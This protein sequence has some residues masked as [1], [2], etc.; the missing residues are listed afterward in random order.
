MSDDVIGDEEQHA[1]FDV[2]PDWKE[3]LWKGMPDYS[4]ENLQ[5]D[6]TL[7]VHFRDLKDREDFARLI[8]QKLHSKTKFIWHPKAEIGTAADKVFRGEKVIPRYPIYI[9][10]KG[11]A[12]TRLTS[13]AFEWAGVPYHIVVEPQEYEQYAAV[14]D[15]SK[16]LVTPFSNLGL[17]GI[18]ARNFVWEH[19]LTTGAKRHWIFDDNISGFCRFQDNLK[20][21]VDNA[22][23]HCAIED[24]CDRYENVKMAAFNYDYFAPRKQGAKIKP[25]TL[26][27]RCYSGILLDN[28]VTHRWRGRY[29]E[30]TDLSLQIL[31]DGDCTALFNAFLMY[32]KPTLTMKGGN[33]D[34]LYAGVEAMAAE[35]ET[36]A[37]SCQQC[38]QCTD[39]YG[40]RITPCDAGRVILEKDGRWRMAE[41]LREQHPDITTVE[42]KWQRW[43]HQVD[44]RAFRPEMGRNVLKLKDGVTFDEGKYALTLDAMPADEPS[45]RGSRGHGTPLEKPRGSAIPAVSALGFL[46][47][48][49][50]PEPI[51]M[52]KPS[53]VQ[54]SPALASPQPEAVAPEPESLAVAADRDQARFYDAMALRDDLGMRGHRLLTRDG[55]FFVSNASELTADEKATIKEHREELIALAEEWTNDRPGMA[56]EHP[57]SGTGVGD[58]RRSGGDAEG[59]SEAPPTLDPPALPPGGTL[60]TLDDLPAH[61]SVDTPSFFSESPST[62]TLAQFLG[63]EPPRIDATYI[64]DE[65]PDLTGIDEIILNFATTG[66]DW[67]NGARPCGVTVSTLDGKLTRF[68][69]FGFKYGGNLDEEA[70]RRWAKEQLRGK[71]ILNA[72]TKF[73]MHQSRNWGIDLEEQ[74][75]TFSD[76]QHTAA[77]LDDHRKRF[78]LDALCQDYFPGQPFV[79]R[80]DETRHS[81]HHA[82]EVA[83]RERFTAQL[84]GRLRERMYPELQ[85]QELMNVQR[86]EDDVI[87]AVVEM[88]KNGSLL[89]VE[90]LDQYHDECQRR[91]KALLM[92][93]SNDV[94]FAFGHTAKDWQR[95]FEKLG[96]PPTDGN[97]EAIISLIDHPIVKKAHLAAQYASLDSKTFAAYKAKVNADGILRFDIN[98]LRS[99]DGGTVSGRFSIGLVQQVPNAGGHKLV[100]GDDLFPRRL[101]IAD[102]TPI[103]DWIPEYLEADAMQIEQRLLVHYM[104]NAKILKEY[105]GDYDRLMRGEETV[106]F[107]R[108]THAMLKVHKPDLVYEHL[109]NF[110]FAFAYGAKSIKLAVMLGFITEE[111]GNEIRANKRWDDPRLKLIKEIEGAYRAM[112]PEAGSLLD[113]AAHLAKTECDEYCKRNDQFH[114]LYAHRGYVKTYEGRRSRYP[115]N[116]KTYSGLNRVLQG[117]GADIMKKKLAALHRERKHTGLLL[118]VT[119]HDAAGGDAQMQETR[120]RVS[121]VLN[122]QSYPLKVPILWS[123]NTGVNWAACK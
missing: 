42:R 37:G 91:H 21:E 84:V 45:A 5:P 38:A 52:E 98:Q 15:P 34:E 61:A 106:S 123:V 111:E 62:Q 6:Q 118:R 115:T 78:A 64:P 3:D 80:V 69:P 30:D 105:E 93:V 96:L 102:R 67:A 73:D 86:L 121:E 79:A 31:K 114:R 32:K 48:L 35:W 100:F 71:K 20:V 24:W 11:R 55:K 66:L 81:E 12:D 76:I 9:I 18:P 54:K 49:P 57:E 8:G 101:F 25:I 107:H 109:K 97:A 87:P 19:A 116:Y 72:R 112:L 1:L 74:G 68:L 29:N 85:A 17:G 27:T 70:V 92:E 77:L 36:H 113:R 108:V 103:G 43:Q 120:V 56:P 7:L 44:Y 10:S 75:C 14:I 104:D 65:P 89:D 88:E 82:S 41:H 22:I 53:P 2:E 40:A 13:K 47:A 83:E 90:L 28:S 50:E 51:R 23:L 58:D 4:H 46:Q 33:T 59:R 39:G 16:I 60:P 95:L 122:A 119:V 117:T 26:N 110:N 63:T 99:D 94:G